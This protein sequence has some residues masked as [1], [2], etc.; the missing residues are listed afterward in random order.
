MELKKPKKLRSVTRKSHPLHSTN[1]QLHG[2]VAQKLTLIAEEQ[3]L[4]RA[5]LIRIVL[6][7]YCEA[8]DQ[9]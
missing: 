3:G 6:R 1:I 5:Q 9:L 4:S 2:D 7:E 8:Y